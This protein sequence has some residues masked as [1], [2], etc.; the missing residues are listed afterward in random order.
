MALIDKVAAYY[1]LE[2]ESG[3]VADA[4]GNSRT[5]T[6]TGVNFSA[7]GLIGRC[8]DNGTTSGAY[9][10]KRTSDNFGVSAWNGARSISMW[11]KLRTEPNSS[12]AFKLATWNTKESGGSAATYVIQY[13]GDDGKHFRIVQSGGGYVYFRYDVTLGTTNWHHVVLTWDGTST[14]GHAKLYLDGTAVATGQFNDGAGSWGTY[15]AS[16]QLEVLAENDVDSFP[17]YLDELG[18][19]SRELSSAEVTTLYNAGVG[20]QYPFTN[21]CASILV[22]PKSSNFFILE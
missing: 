21:D 19:W 12:Q 14:A 8:A 6:N 3:D 2:E 9:Y 20:C 4:S 13:R 22:L 1:K 5:L 17:C 11:V 15:P 16:N 10:F 7:S 18:V